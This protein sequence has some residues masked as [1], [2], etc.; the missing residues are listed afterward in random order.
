MTW[1]PTVAR[2]CALFTVHERELIGARISRVP[3]SSD[4]RIDVGDQQI[5][6]EPTA[7]PQLEILENA[8]RVRD[9]LEPFDAK[10]VEANRR[11]FVDSKGDVD[12]PCST[13]A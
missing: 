11:A 13:P 9:E 3:Q 4:D 10:R 12:A 2:C 8:R 7:D 6:P 1:I 5:A